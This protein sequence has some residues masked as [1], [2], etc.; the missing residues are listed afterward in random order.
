[1]I[2]AT[3]P[4]HSHVIQRTYTGQPSANLRPA[5]AAANTYDKTWMKSMIG[6]HE[7][8]NRR[9]IAQL[10]SQPS[11]TKARRTAFCQQMGISLL[12]KWTWFPL[13]GLHQPI[14]LEKESHV[15]DVTLS[16]LRSRRLPTLGAADR[17]RHS[18]L[19]HRAA[20]RTAAL[21]A[22]RLGPR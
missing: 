15:H 16:R 21:F 2:W 10:L 8:K 18:D 6:V 14:P 11:P 7:P 13:M 22:V 5:V 17:R 12:N 9:Q 4:C 1:M 20:T 19:L 3:W